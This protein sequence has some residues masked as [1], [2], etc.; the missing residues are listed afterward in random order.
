MKKVQ[1]K[2]QHP[3]FS[4]EQ[5][6]VR[7]ILIGFIYSHHI[8]ERISASDIG[9]TFCKL[10][11]H[12][13]YEIA[14][15]PYLLEQL[16]LLH[17]TDLVRFHHSLRVAVTSGIV[18]LAQRYDSQQLYEL[19]IGALLF[20]IGMTQLPERLIHKAG[21]LTKEERSEMET[22][23]VLGYQM[24]SSHRDVPQAA[25][26]CALMHHER[27]DGSGYPHQLRQPHLHPY[28]QIVGI[29][30]A[31]NA[32]ISPRSYRSACTRHEALEYLYGASHRLFDV[33]LVE[34]FT[35]H[36]CAYPMNS[37]VLLSNGKI[38]VVSMIDYDAIQRPVVKVIREPD[39]TLIHPSY[40][41]DLKKN[42]DVVI[43]NAL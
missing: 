5:A 40:E 14:S 30:D 17:Q 25:A 27:L 15:H 22:H 37:K 4:N 42:L 24:L 26:L 12:I 11:R 35:Q 3:R 41:I 43:V 21:P 19:T 16:T 6:V 39:G 9:E 8:K 7:D 10:Y 38:G 31:Y 2:T 23:T 13:F 34:T 36:I 32:L 28:A 33:T 29:S 1:R 18:G 20:D